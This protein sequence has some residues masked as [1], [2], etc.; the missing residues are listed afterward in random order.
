MASFRHSTSIPIQILLA[1]LLAACSTNTF[2]VVSTP[3]QSDIFLEDAQTGDKKSIGQ[4]PLEIPM[5]QVDD[6][7]NSEASNGEF[8][9]LIIEKAGFLP[10]RLAL[11]S[12]HFGTMVTSLDVK[13][14]EGDGAK[15][16]GVA[17]D[18]LNRF[19]L[20]QKLTL[21]HEYDRAQAEI[22]KILATAPNF[23][24]AY[25]MR[26]SIY[27]VQNNMAESSKWYN[28]ALQH[29]PQMEDAVKMIARTSGGV[30]GAGTNRMPASAAPAIPLPAAPPAGA[31][32]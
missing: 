1:G 29:D 18:I 17:E 10:Q 13:L 14:K 11:P 24:R 4:T 31:K 20:A 23:A 6:M 9:T 21:N 15:Q 3:A 30:S 7:I 8:V 28:L 26:G 25:S 19:F 32:P 22:D 12:A 2:K 16:I 5:S 27:Y